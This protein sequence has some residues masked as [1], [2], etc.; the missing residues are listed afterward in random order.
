M[1]FLAPSAR[2]TSKARP[3]T[4]LPGPPLNPGFKGSRITECSNPDDLVKKRI[5][6]RGWVAGSL[7]AA[8]AAPVKAKAR[9]R[10]ASGVFMGNETI[11]TNGQRSTASS[12]GPRAPPVPLFGDLGKRPE[13]IHL[14]G[15]GK[16]EVVQA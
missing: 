8:R 16:L 6:L 15:P 3:A 9:S 14:E 7:E 5:R 1:L 10:Q 11:G 13:K 12:G 4:S 2:R